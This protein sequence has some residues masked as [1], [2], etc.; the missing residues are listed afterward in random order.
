M[1]HWIDLSKFDIHAIVTSNVQKISLGMVSFGAAVFSNLARLTIDSLITVVILFFP[2][3]RRQRVGLPR[4]QTHADLGR[5]R[6]PPIPEHLRHHH[7]QRLR[8][9]HGRLVQGILT[10]IAMKIVGMP[11]AML[12]G[13]GAGFA[14]I[15]PVVGSSLV[16]GPVA[17]YFLSRA[18]WEKVVFPASL[19]NRCRQLDR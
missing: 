19:G 11:S 17:I 5:S 8:H 12:L 10:G 9:T 6:Q 4:R 18:R 13:L 1:G 14:S 2:L 15:I 3:P 7:R 16:W